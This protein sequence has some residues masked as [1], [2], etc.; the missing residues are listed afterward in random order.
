MKQ[1]VTLTLNE[2]AVAYLDRLVEEE[3]TNRS[4]IVE[5]IIVDYIHD[6]R[7]AELARQAAAFFA[8]P[9]RAAEAAERQDWERLSA[10]TLRDE[11]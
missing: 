5:Q 8:A 11:P 7:Q 3:A 4:M 6:R 1:R 10:E 2:D 9:E